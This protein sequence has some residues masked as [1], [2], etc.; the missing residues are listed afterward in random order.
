[1]QVS[2]LDYLMQLN[3][4]AGRRM[5]NPAFHPTLPWVIDMSAPPEPSMH[6]T[7]EACTTAAQ[8]DAPLSSSRQFLGSMTCRRVYNI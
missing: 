1:M 8:P 6:A 3:H 4:L 2:N 7:R 5:G